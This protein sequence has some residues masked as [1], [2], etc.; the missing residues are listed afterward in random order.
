MA[1]SL[2][3]KSSPTILFYKNGKQ[4]GEVLNGAVKRSEIIR[5]KRKSGVSKQADDI[6]IR[7]GNH[8]IAQELKQLG[9][10]RLLA[11]SYAPEYQVILTPVIESFAC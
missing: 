7:F 3:I 2:N 8:P 9:L 4:I 6:Q 11:Y 10:G 5:N 1:E